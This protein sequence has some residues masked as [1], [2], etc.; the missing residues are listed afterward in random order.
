MTN[1]TYRLRDPKFAPFI[2]ARILGEQYFPFQDYLRIYEVEVTD[3]RKPEWVQTSLTPI[4]NAEHF[5]KVF[6]LDS[7]A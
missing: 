2:T 5:H 7:V 3:S 4:W 6:A 1:S